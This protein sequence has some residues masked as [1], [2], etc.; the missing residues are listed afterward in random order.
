MRVDL[1][2]LWATLLILFMG[3]A[4]PCQAAET[5]GRMEAEDLELL[6]LRSPTVFD[7]YYRFRELY[8]TRHPYF[9]LQVDLVSGPEFTIPTL[10]GDRTAAVQG[11]FLNIGSVPYMFDATSGVRIGVDAFLAGLALRG[12][13]DQKAGLPR[14]WDCGSL[15]F[16]AS[17]FDTAKGWTATIGSQV[18]TTPYTQ[19]VDGKRV[20]SHLP[21]E[22]TKGQVDRNALVLAG[23]VPTPWFGIDLGVVIAEDG[24]ETVSAQGRML[25]TDVVKSFGPHVASYPQLDNYQAGLH[26]DGLRIWDPWLEL[27]AEASMRWTPGAGI[28]FDHA[29]IKTRTVFFQ[30]VAHRNQDFRT[31][32]A[33]VDTDFHLGLNLH[34]SF[35]NLDAGGNP[36]GGGFLVEFLSIYMWGFEGTISLGA[37][38]NF[39]ED[40]LQLPMPNV[41]TGRAVL[42]V[43]I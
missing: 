22:E 20:F 28:A 21:E 2:A 39:Y 27:S 30:D 5:L 34:A 4:S 13:A 7:A 41:L 33:K 12:T 6:A 40:L 31:W 8:Q 16:Y 11:A 3:S 17:L 15:L 14:S 36:W 18:R 32:D 42:S 1:P 29:Y 26:L 38:Y 19:V 10:L 24:F 43:G 37:G 23:T 35:V 9:F 25:S